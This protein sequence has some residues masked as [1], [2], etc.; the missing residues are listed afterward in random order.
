[1]AGPA[2]TLAL[3][4]LLPQILDLRLLVER[5]LAD[6]IVAAA[7]LGALLRPEGRLFSARVG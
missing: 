6:G 3:L 5:G 2:E 4:V 1:M 7:A